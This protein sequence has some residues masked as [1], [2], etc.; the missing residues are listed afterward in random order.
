MEGHVRQA[1]CIQG[2]LKIYIIRR[3][4]NHAILQKKEYGTPKSGDLYKI[5]SR[6][7]TMHYISAYPVLGC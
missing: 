2:G 3:D 5:R 4:M 7:H 6:H 1:A